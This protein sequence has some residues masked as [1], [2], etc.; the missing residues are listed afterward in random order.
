MHTA[1]DC[2]DGDDEP[3]SG[4]AGE[5]RRIVAQAEPA[6]PGER[7]KEAPD[8]AEFAEPAARHGAL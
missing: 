7:R 5:E 1:D 2:I 4:I 8:A 3:L 6:G